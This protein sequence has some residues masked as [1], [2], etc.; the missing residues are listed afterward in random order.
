[1]GGPSSCLGGGRAVALRQRA[2]YSDLKVHRRA[3]RLCSCGR[4][5]SGFRCNSR[6]PAHNR[7]ARMA[8]VRPPIGAGVGLYGDHRPADPHPKWSNDPLYEAK[9]GWVLAAYKGAE[10]GT[11][12]GVVVSFDECGRSH[13]NLRP[14]PAGSPRRNRPVSGPPT[15]AVT[16]PEITPTTTTGPNSPKPPRPTSAGATATPTTRASSNSRTAAK[17]PGLPAEQSAPPH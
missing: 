3:R 1:M 7:R 17:S 12:D 5:M 2:R 11:I 15:T 9:K 16:E 13:S 10:A 6:P 4:G 14:V 8:S